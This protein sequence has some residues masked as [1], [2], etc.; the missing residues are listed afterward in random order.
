VVCRR[1]VAAGAVE[2]SVIPEP[3]DSAG[4]RAICGAAVAAAA[5]AGALAAGSAGAAAAE[6][7]A[8]A[9]LGAVTATA[10]GW[11]ADVSPLEPTGVAA[12]LASAPVA[13]AGAGR[14]AVWRRGAAAANVEA[15]V[16]DSA[17]VGDLRGGS[18]TV[19]FGTGAAGSAGVASA[20]AT[21]VCVA[22]RASDPP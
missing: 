1:G 15:A 18:W 17:V 21:G 4:R 6:L 13:V 16:G 14:S 19:A 8:A 7:P 3:A 12:W 22:L 20:G 2:A 11:A 10:V 9:C 5:V